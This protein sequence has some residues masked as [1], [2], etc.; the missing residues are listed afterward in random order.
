[1][2]TQVAMW[3]VQEKYNV[4]KLY[5]SL[6]YAFFFLFLSY[7]RFATKY[8]ICLL[9]EL[10]LL[11]GGGGGGGAITKRNPKKMGKTLPLW[12][13]RKKRGGGGEEERGIA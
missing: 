6:V 11:V 3:W 5:L 10:V 9:F 12:R 4:G 8:Q 13:E 7:T 2:L 1:M